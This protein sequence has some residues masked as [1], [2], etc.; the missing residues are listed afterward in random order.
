[1][2]LPRS[3]LSELLDAIR[4]GDGLD[5]TREAFRLVAQ[6]PIGLEATQAIGA[7]RYERVDGRTAD[8]NGSR[9]R[10]LS[11]MAGDVELRVR[12]SA[13]AASSP[14][15][16]SPGVASTGRWA[17]VWRHTST[18]SRPARSTTRWCPGHRGRHQQE[19]GVAHRPYIEP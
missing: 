8:R 6:E 5:L 3:A 18:A 19:R 14:R 11:T 15:S 12:S 9:T 4:A 17:V 1:M 10:L 16:R 7:R 13:R 2:P